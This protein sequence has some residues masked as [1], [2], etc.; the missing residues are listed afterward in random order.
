[1]DGYTLKLLNV[2][3]AS[4]VQK[5]EEALSEH[6]NAENFDVN[7]A[8]RRIEVKSDIKPS[9]VINSLVNIGYEAKVI[10][11]Q[12]EDD[13]DEEAEVNK[14]FK[15][16]FV[17]G[18]LGIIMFI[19]GMSTFNPPLTS[20]LGQVL[21]LV[22]GL[23]SLF[24]IWF[25]GRHL[26]I[27]AYKAFLNHH[28]TMDTLITIGTASAWI[29]SMVIT[30]HP[31]LVPE[32]SRHVYF[33]A[34]LIIIALVN[35][36]AGLEVRARGKTSQAI[37]RLIG[38]QA[39]TARIVTEQGEEIDAPIDSLKAG[40]LIRVR[41]GEKVAVDGQ[42]IEGHS[43]IDESMLTGESMPVSKST[44]DMVFGSTINKTGTFLFK[45]T[46]VGS[47]TVLS[48]I[49]KLVGQAQSTK[50]PIAKL[51]DVASSYFV[52][53]VLIISVITAMIWYNL[54]FGSG[55][56]L[57][58]SMTVLVIACPCALGLA[59]PISV[60]VGMGKSAENGILIRNGEALQ[61]AS[62]LGAIVLDKTGTITKGQPD[63]IKII[64]HSSFDE[65][66][67][68]SFAASLEQGSEHPLAIAII[69]KAKEKQL[70]LFEIKDFKAEVGHGVSS[71]IDDKRVILGNDKFLIENGIEISALSSQAID[72][73]NKGQT[74]IY[75]GIDNELAGIIAIADPIK[76]ESSK[77]VKQLKELGLKVVMITGD[78]ELTANAIAKLSEIEDVIA[79]A[80][81]ADKAEHV[82]R[83]QAKDMIVAMVGDGIN[84]APALTQAD[85][86]FA[87]GAG[88]DVAI[89]S[90][91]VTLISNSIQGVINAIII[92]KATMR[93]IK[94]N[95]FG[96]FI[97]NMIGIPIAAGILYPL[98]SVLLNPMIAGAAMAASSLTVVSNANRLRLLKVGEVK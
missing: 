20:M 31:T 95:L 7:F 5:I 46:K 29:Y 8:D 21:W 44:D 28:A 22:L 71:L 34:A 94:Q 86:G 80:L 68:L 39:K 38:L 45:A 72:M 15:Q 47:D 79:S 65:N 35:L 76:D 91:D 90:A 52:P 74:P 48:Q 61:K 41:P 30:I 26:Y 10:D 25:S 70:P 98:F 6:L 42:I 93:N 81:P 62:Q 53:V 13:Y 97:Y 1:M 67:V 17:A 82:K 66:V 32:G 27:S 69:N 19:V 36:G 33:E 83:L 92:S 12:V 64:P 50:P 4:C 3:C 57:V 43:S 56:I 37:K 55:Y 24:G 58:S 63:V 77:A 85:I 78:N 89:E 88:S 60:I 40:D 54:G 87:I 96:A 11:E 51:A 9:V 49:V 2:H 84:D 59:A 73:A 75:L 16:A 23:L 14:L 18:V